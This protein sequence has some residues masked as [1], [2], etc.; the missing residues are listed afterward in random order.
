M[1][2]L[3]GVVLGAAL[4]TAACGGNVGEKKP[5]N[6]SGSMD[7][8]SMTEVVSPVRNTAGDEIGS[9]TLVQGPSG[10]S[11]KVDVTGLTPGEHGIHFH[12]TGVCVAPDFKESA[13]GHFNPTD[14]KHGLDHPDGHHAGDL[15]N[16]MADENGVAQSEFTT[17]AVTLNLGEKN[18]LLDGDGTAL[19]IHDGADD[20][21]TDPSGNSGKAFACAEITSDY[22]K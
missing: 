19:I 8:E 20:Y 16:I 21:R 12:E 10:V 5:V 11:L 18:S 1:W 9:V 22:V 2:K 4:L 6:G 13:G 15:E 7:G 3:S 17:N 14:K